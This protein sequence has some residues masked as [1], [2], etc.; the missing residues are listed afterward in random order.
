MVVVDGTEA[1]CYVA[2]GVL[3]GRWQPVDERFRDYI[4][5][6]KYNMYRSLHTPSWSAASRSAC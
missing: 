4:S 2:L 5:M 3:H 6:P 1:D